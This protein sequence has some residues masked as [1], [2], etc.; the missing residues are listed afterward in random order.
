MVFYGMVDNTWTDERLIGACLDG[1]ED[2]WSTII[3][4]YRA[5]IYSVPFKQGLP[6]DGATDVFQDVCLSLLSEIH[7]IRQPNALA[8]WLIRTAWYKSIHWKRAQHKYLIE[9]ID[10][11]RMAR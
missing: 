6:P 2:A 5:L 1:N 3:D 11:E 9:E 4:R 8:A 7:Q 10:D